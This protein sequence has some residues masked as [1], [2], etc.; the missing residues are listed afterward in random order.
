MVPLAGT[1]SL[2]VD[3]EENDARAQSLS[4][5]VL[6]DRAANP[7]RWTASRSTSP[8]LVRDADTRRRA[9]VAEGII[10]R[11]ADLPDQAIGR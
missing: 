5:S 1:F 4:L 6:T 10:A 8:Q 7:S 2:L 11:A 9:H 3:E